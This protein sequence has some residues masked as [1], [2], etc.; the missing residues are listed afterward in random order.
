[1]PKR[2]MVIQ[3]HPDAQSGRLCHA[4][5]QQYVEGAH[6]A[7]S[8]IRQFDIG[9]MEFP[10]LRKKSDFDLGRSGTPKA[11]VAA[12]ESLL[13][14][15]HLMLIYPL[16]HGTMPAL[17][18]GFIEQVFRPDVAEKQVV[19]GFPKR[20]LSG[21]SARIVI[22]MGM[23]AWAYRWYF[24]AHS[25]KSLE[26]NILKFS[27]ISPV[28]RSLFGRVENVSPDTRNGWLRKMRKAGMQDA[29]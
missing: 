2:L 3:G 15:Q 1:M 19:Q 28:H 29:H 4:L 9:Q 11:L 12:Q 10:L 18:K 27:G 5:A 7:G 22:T 26:R 6:L 25:L 8:E 17:L 13:W 24:G 21:R 20:M 16:W 23:P 14:A